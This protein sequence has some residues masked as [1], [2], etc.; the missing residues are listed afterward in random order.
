MYTYLGKVLYTTYL[1]TFSLG[2]CILLIIINV[3]T[4]QERYVVVSSKHHNYKR[5]VCSSN[6]R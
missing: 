5:A 1:D 6:N 2:F 3:N 4:L